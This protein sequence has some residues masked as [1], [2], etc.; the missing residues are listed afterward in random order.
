[1]DKPIIPPE[2]DV[3]V[4]IKDTEEN[5]RRTRIPNGPDRVIGN[6]IFIINIT[7]PRKDLYVPLSVASGKKPTGFV[8]QIEGT[9][10]SSIL[11]TDISCRGENITQVALGTIVYCKIPT[12]MTA[13]FRIRIET[14]GQVGKLYKIVIRQIR[15]KLNP[16]DARYQI[17]LENLE[18]KMLKFS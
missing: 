14:R 7:A 8:Y 9:A 4:D 13:A 12:G 3:L 1:M 5:L 10:Q 18:T 11:K 6:F 2:K 15:Y 16:L 17:L